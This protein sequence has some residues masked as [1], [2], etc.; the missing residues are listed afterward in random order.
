KASGSSPLMVPPQ[1]ST[2]SS[3]LPNAVGA[4]MS[5]GR[6]RDL[7][8]DSAVMPSDAIVIRSVGVA[9][10]NHSPGVDAGNAVRWAADQHRPVPILFICEDNGIGISVPTPNEWIESQYGSRAGL[11]Y[12]R[13]DG[14]SLCDTYLAAREA[15]RY[16]RVYRKP[17][18]LH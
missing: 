7:K 17:V 2:I 4:A 18:F 11:Y 15:E 9:S 12:I 8:L 13:C 1:T 14:L 3:H 16:A 10:I 6:A 5:I